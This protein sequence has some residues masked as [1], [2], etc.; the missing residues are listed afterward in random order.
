M[1]RRKRDLSRGEVLRAALQVAERDGLEALTMRKVAAEVGVEAMSL[2]GHVGDK[3]DM[4]DGL[5]EVV[6][7]MFDMPPVSG[8]WVADAR[9]TARAFRQLAMRYPRVAPLVLTRQSWSS[10]MLRVTDA[11]VT[12]LL[13]AGFSPEQSVHALRAVL[14]TVVGSLL[15]EFGASPTLGGDDDAGHDVRVQRIAAAELPGLNRVAEQLATLA[16]EAEFEFALNLVLSAL[17]AV[18][19]QA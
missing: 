6:V 19:A 4:L 18:L 15:R 7:E 2:Y 3:D 1:A 16:P 8:D 11:L 9:A 10:P 14:G 12:I 13:D 17:E 5:V